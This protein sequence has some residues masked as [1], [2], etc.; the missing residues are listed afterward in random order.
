MLPAGSNAEVGKW[1]YY[2]AYYNARQVVETPRLVFA[3]FDGDTLK[4]DDS[5]YSYDGSLLSYNP[6]DGE[7]KC[8]SILTGLSD[9]NIRHMAYC[10]EA[11]ALM[12]VYEN[13]NI[14]IMTGENEIYNLPFIKD[15]LHLTGK[16]V[17]NLEIIGKYGYIS[18]DFGVVIVD[19]EKKAIKDDCRLGSTRSVCLWG[20]TLLAVTEKGIMKAAVT[21]NLLDT[22]NWTLFEDLVFEEGHLRLIDKILMFNGKLVIHVWGNV[23]YLHEPNI[24]LA[25]GENVRQVAVTDNKLTIATP[26]ELLIYSDFS[27]VQRL[28]IDVLSFDGIRSGRYWAGLPGGKGL[29]AIDLRDNEA[30]YETTVNGI[31]MNSPKR[32][33]NSYMTSA[34][35]K[36]LVTGGGRA[37]NRMDNAG[38]FSVYENGQ[39]TNFDEKQIARD[40]GIPACKD[41]MS[42]AIDPKNSN[43][44]FVGSWGEG[45][46]EF[47]NNRFVNRYNH[48]NTGGKLQSAIPTTDNYARITG[49]VFD[50]ND[51]NL[52]MVNGDVENAMVSFSAAGTWENYYIKPLSETRAPDNILID[53]NNYKWLNIWR[54]LSG[55]SFGSGIVVLDENNRETGSSDNFFDQ[56][57]AGIEATAYLC[58]VEALDGR[59]WVGTDNGPIIISSPQHVETGECTRIVAIDEYGDPYYLLEGEKINVIAVD[60]GDRKWMGSESNGVY[61]VEQRDGE[62]Y[63]ENFNT[64]NSPILSN[65]INAIAINNETGEVFIGTENGICSYMSHV[66]PGKPDFSSSVRAFPNPVRPASDTQVSITGLMQNSTV[67]ITDMAGNLIHQGQSVGSLFTWNCT[68]RSGETVKAGIYLVFAAAE[69]GAMGIVTKIMVIK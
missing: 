21:S 6:D 68:G 64:S 23:L 38:T 48:L 43:R 5:Q 50:R 45:L 65:R 17:N 36:L 34:A 47:E 8:Y 26:G 15:N 53:R 7:V 40:A 16:T 32:N 61:L 14:D 4:S 49:L 19:I 41:F 24:I 60:G 57:G 66:T 44:Y 67:K 62:T 1:T 37:G 69:D 18:T 13:A 20:D 35:G 25:L 28:P 22:E 54:S 58:M 30:G 29:A 9:V 39:W 11:G 33:L 2:R 10:P 46:Y 51:N 52:F 55:V 27:Q 42:A 12:L 31:T 59:V 56:N 3:V 63:V